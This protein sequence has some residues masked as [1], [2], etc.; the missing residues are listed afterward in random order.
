MHIAAPFGRKEVSGS[1]FVK[2][3]PKKLL[4]LGAGAFEL[5]GTKVAVFRLG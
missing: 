5:P 4:R 2:K 3:E 1:F